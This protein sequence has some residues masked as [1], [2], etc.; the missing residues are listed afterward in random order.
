[1]ARHSRSA[2]S[3]RIADFDEQAWTTN[4]AILILAGL[5]AGVVIG[6]GD[7][8][9]LR[10]LYNGYTHLAIVGVMLGLLFI[11]ARW[12]EGKM[13]RRLQLAV[14]LSLIAHMASVILICQ[15]PVAIAFP[16]MKKDRPGGGR[17]QPDYQ[18][19]APDY[20][21]TVVEQSD[22]DQDFN[23]PVD[24]VAPDE[25]ILPATVERDDVERP[26]PVAELPRLPQP[27]SA[28]PLAPQEQAFPM[29]LA[30][31]E[32]SRPQPVE[33]P[34]SGRVR[35]ERK[36]TDP[37]APELAAS[38]A[39]VTRPAEARPVAEASAL[40]PGSVAA[41]RQASG[42]PR[43]GARTASDPGLERLGP[44]PAAE[45]AGPARRMG[46]GIELAQAGPPS[47]T[48]RPGDP[49]LP[50]DASEAA[51][52]P[53]AAK[54]PARLPDAGSTQ[55]GRQQTG[56]P[57]RAG[58][59]AIEAGR[60]LPAMTLVAQLPAAVA[61]RSGA[62]QPEAGGS[63]PMPSRP[64][65]LRRT[66]RGG[67]S[68]PSRSLLNE[69][70]VAM[71]PAAAGGVVGSRIEAASDVAVE[72]AG[73]EK[74][75]AGKSIAARGSEE[76]GT[77]AGQRIAR[78]GIPRGRGDER[79]SL[80]PTGPALRLARTP[81][82]TSLGGI[83]GTEG[84]LPTV[85]ASPY[86]GQPAGPSTDASVRIGRGTTGPGT[87][88]TARGDG[89]SSVLR[90]ADS[91]PVGSRTA[92]TSRGRAAGPISSPG[93]T[94]GSHDHGRN[95]RRRRQAGPRRLGPWTARRR[96]RRGCRRGGDRDGTIDPR[97]ARW[98]T[99]GSRRQG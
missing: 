22:V 21:W 57:G 16:T 80:N 71:A 34:G 5:L 42:T 18:L 73:A 93:N 30:R 44:A 76:F 77:G 35:R 66:D 23:T 50:A 88:F 60:A 65:T 14:L 63:D 4:I 56:G 38:E 64:G 74:A 95:V 12:L 51:P 39:E 37:S 91:R 32:P 43:G 20:H 84:A 13:R 40:Q 10:L 54:E 90:V 26:T 58:T 61:P 85:I 31:A 97:R 9:D 62:S 52:G 67:I 11:A 47:R 81:T 82:G 24:A 48:R 99:V 92:W 78:I 27:E 3:S 98:R 79:P 19:V 75:P 29:E 46:E 72:R 45:V 33:E 15:F 49:S 7:F 53:L 94:A 55:V 83:P 68:M 1:M 87:E 89:S 25:E 36:P 41:S 69:T 28:P 59:S 8:T 17:E 2:G 6:I 86:A 70:E 96:R